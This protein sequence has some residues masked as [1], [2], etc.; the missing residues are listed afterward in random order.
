MR[1]AAIAAGLACCAVAAPVTAASGQAGHGETGPATANLGTGIG[2]DAFAPP[3]VDV[4]A[5]D[6]VTWTNRSVRQHTVTSVDE[7]WSSDRL[8]PKDT[9]AHRFDAAGAFPYF[10]RLHPFMRGEVDVHR[11]LITPPAAPAAPGRPFPIDGRAALP[12]GGSVSIEADDGTGFRPA[13]NAIVAGDGTF[14]T[15]VTP[16]TVATYRAV[17]GAEASPAVQLL[18]LDRRI[19]ARARTRG[20]SVVVSARVTPASAGTTVVLQLRLPERFGWWPVARAKLNGA[21]AA[22]FAVRLRRRVPARV[23][24]TLPDGATS[25][26]TSRTLRVGSRASARRLAPRASAGA[27]ESGAPS[28][29]G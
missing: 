15:T 29:H 7:S 21:S 1:R 2:F 16:R 27:G 5:G 22:R 23:V 12:A 19:S 28:H 14:S 26:A 8:F 18:V 24:L 20:R 9:F 4:L 17:A 25:L 10:C 6:T 3:Q 13:G 11:L